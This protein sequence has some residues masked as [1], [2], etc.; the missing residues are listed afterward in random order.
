MRITD[1]PELSAADLTEDDVVAVDH[2]TG[3]GIETRRMT[4]SDLLEGLN[5]S[6]LFGLTDIE[7]ISAIKNSRPHGICLGD[8]LTTAQASAIAAG[9]FEGICLGDYWLK[10]G[11]HWRVCGFNYW[12]KTGGP[13]CMTPLVVIMPDEALYQTTMEATNTTENGY[14]NSAMRKTG[15]AQAKSIISAMFGAEH[16]LTHREHLISAASEGT[17]TKYEEFDCGVE[18]PSETMMYGGYIFCP[19]NNAA[20]HVN[21]YTMSKTQL[22]LY[23]VCPS[24][25]TVKNGQFWLRDLTSDIG[26]AY[27][28]AEGAA[29]DRPA[30]AGYD[31]GVRPVFGLM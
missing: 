27:V 11:I 2:D 4:V 19:A 20:S 29:S 15:L 16:L 28:D 14:A 23:V 17:A 10:D 5:A 22:P 30:G 25:I 13:L 18:L 7:M 8:T 31:C 26:F 1:L 3:N 21:R 24:R 9:T 6:C 12:Y